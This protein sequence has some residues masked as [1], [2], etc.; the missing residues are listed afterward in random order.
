MKNTSIDTYD[1]NREMAT[2]SVAEDTYGTAND[3]VFVVEYNTSVNVTTKC[4]SV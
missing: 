1:S 3:G 4:N 2:M